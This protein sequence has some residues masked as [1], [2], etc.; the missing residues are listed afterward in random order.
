[1]TQKPPPR[2]FGALDILAGKVQLYGYP[3][4]FI[5]IN[6]PGTDSSFAAAELLESQGWRVVN[7]ADEGRKVFLR[8]E[9][10][11]TPGPPTQ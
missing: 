5:V 8:R 4:T 3:F 11:L 10:R 9:H 7:F 6:A 1:M 2:T